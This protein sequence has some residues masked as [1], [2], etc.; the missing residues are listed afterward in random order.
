MHN[1]EWSE[2]IPLKWLFVIPAILAGLNACFLFLARAEPK[3]QMSD[4]AM[5]TVSG[6]FLGI[7]LLCLI[8]GVMSKRLAA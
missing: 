3:M 7:A 1:R 5:G 8:V 4:F 6:V 2:K